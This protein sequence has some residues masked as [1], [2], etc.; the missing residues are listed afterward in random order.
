MALWF[1]FVFFFLEVQILF[2]LAKNLDYV[3]ASVHTTAVNS[4]FFPCFY[5]VLQ[6]THLCGRILYIHS[7][8]CVSSDLSKLLGHS[9]VG[10]MDMQVQCAVVTLV[11]SNC[12][13]K[14]SCPLVSFV[15]QPV[16]RNGCRRMR[17]RWSDSWVDTYRRRPESRDYLLCNITIAESDLVLHQH[18]SLSGYGPWRKRQISRRVQAALHLE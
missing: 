9:C 17:I 2:P 14:L 8:F 10:V 15:L 3:G 6:N 16:T 13:K 7:R 1:Y 5:N 12:L 18:R 11:V 4:V